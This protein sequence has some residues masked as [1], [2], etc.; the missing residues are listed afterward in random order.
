[1]EWSPWQRNHLSIK[2]VVSMAADPKQKQL[3]PI[4]TLKRNISNSKSHHL[5]RS[6][7]LV[8]FLCKLGCPVLFWLVCTNG[9]PHRQWP[10]TLFSE[11]LCRCCSC[12]SIRPSF[13]S[14]SLVYGSS[15]FMRGLCESPFTSLSSL[16]KLFLLLEG[17]RVQGWIF[18]C[19]RVFS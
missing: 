5:W 11:T 6:W 10:L 1:M 8:P 4:F 15:Q 13:C 2:A 19:V 9:K 7:V 17:F 18:R 12:S 3:S 14:P 16:E